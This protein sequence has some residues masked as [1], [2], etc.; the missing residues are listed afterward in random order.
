[1]A[2]SE[3]TDAIGNVLIVDDGTPVDLQA[4]SP[5]D[6]GALK[7]ADQFSENNAHDQE[8]HDPPVRTNRPDQPIIQRL[9]VGAG[10]HEPPPADAGVD[11]YGRYRVNVDGK[12]VVKTAFADEKENKK[13]QEQAD[14][15]AKANAAPAGS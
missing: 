12:P 14:V 8:L 5:K 4:E 15:D 2:D 9:G 6:A 1:M 13:R 10:Q 11:E 3:P 7:Q